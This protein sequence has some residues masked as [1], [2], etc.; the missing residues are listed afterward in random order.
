MLTVLI[1][2]LLLMVING[3]LVLHDAHSIRV[4]MRVRPG[5]QQGKD[6][7]LNITVN[8][9]KKLLAAGQYT[10]SLKPLE[11][12]IGTTVISAVSGGIVLEVYEERTVRSF[13]STSSRRTRIQASK[14]ALSCTTLAFC[15]RGLPARKKHSLRIKSIFNL[16]KADGGAKKPLPSAFV[17]LRKFRR[18]DCENR[19]F[20]K[21]SRQIFDDVVYWR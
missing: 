11:G 6:V 16:T 10:A 21:K 2:L 18:I 4:S 15:T 9:D 3:M 13:W 1:V 14:R 8:S 5:G 20:C 12:R 17:I 7:N 19:W